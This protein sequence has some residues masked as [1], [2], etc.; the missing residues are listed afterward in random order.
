MT[1]KDYRMMFT[2]ADGSQAVMHV[3]R[4]F[5]RTHLEE[6]CPCEKAPCGLVERWVDACPEHNPFH[7]KTMRQGHSAENCPGAE[8]LTL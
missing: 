4:S 3:G 8:Q 2:L 5:T 7:A 6:R 1:S